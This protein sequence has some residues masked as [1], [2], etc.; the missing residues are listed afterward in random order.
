M[1][2]VKKG[3][4]ESVAKDNRNKTGKKKGKA[5]RI[6]TITVLAFFVLVIIFGFVLVKMLNAT[7]QKQDTSDSTVNVFDTTPEALQNKVAYYVV[8][9]LGEDEKTSTTERLTIVCHDKKKNTLNILEVPQDTY[10]GDSDLWAV[11]KAGDVWGNPAPLDWCEFEGKRIYKAEIEEHKTAGHTVTQKKG[12]QWY[13]VVSIFNEQYA[14]PVDGYFFISQKSFVKLVDL[15]G[16]VDVELESAMTLADIKYGAGVKTLDGAGALDY[17]C[18]RDKGVKGD[19]ARIVR[20][21]K[22]FLALFQRLCAQSE[23]QL[24]NDSLM[25]LLKGSTPI[26]TNLSTTQTLELVLS[27]KSV[28]PDKMTAQLLPGEVTAF[29]SNSYYTVHRQSLAAALNA[30]FHPYDNEVTEADLQ[31]VELATGKDEDT[32]CQVLSEIQ[33][34][35][36]GFAQPSDD[37]GTEETKKSE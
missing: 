31:V 8:G 29:N 21:R 28:T 6:L 20:Q 23:E 24:N 7:S 18:K 4:V 33:V 27:L 35:Q 26:R 37:K 10:L 12:S 34:E 11:K 14:L 3:Q 9:L 22:V 36:S 1:K 25:P 32:H 19:L 17:V 13:N 2:N 15:L 16:G 5:G 30:D